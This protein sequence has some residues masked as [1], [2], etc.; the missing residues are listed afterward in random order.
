MDIECQTIHCY[1]T[2]KYNP[3]I[4]LTLD[5]SVVVRIIAHLCEDCTLLISTNVPYEPFSVRYGY[6]V[7]NL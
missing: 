5:N 4:K 3:A 1:K 2:A 7:P 6:A